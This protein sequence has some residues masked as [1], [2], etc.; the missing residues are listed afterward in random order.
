MRQTTSLTTFLLRLF[1][2]ARAARVLHP[3][4]SALVGVA[5]LVLTSGAAWAQTQLLNVSYDPTRELHRDLSQEFARM[6]KEKTGETVVIRSSHGGSGKQARAVI[7]GLRRR[8]GHP[9]ARGRHRRDRARDQEDPGGLAEAAA[10]QLLALHLDDRLRG[11]EGQSEGHQGLGRPREA[12]ASQVITPNPKTSGGA[13]WNYLA[14]WGYA[15]DK[16][17]GDEAKARDFVA[18][19]LQERAGARYG[20]ARLDHDL[21]P[22]RHRRRA[23]RLGERGLPGAQGVRRRQV[24]DRRARPSRSWPNR[25]S[26]WSTATS[27]RRAR[28]RRRRPISNSSIPA[29]AQAIIAKNYYRPIKPEAADPADLARFPKLEL[30]TIDEVFGGWDKAQSDAFRRRRHVRPDLSS[31]NR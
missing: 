8:R 13:R 19:H 21:R 12:R 27:T 14:A 26:R 2:R 24:R 17:E 3:S 4:R 9:G 16:S 23:D 31:A 29:Q 15:L 30:V 18:A 25:R 7:D 1:A 11:A 28:A 5:A 22:A 20:R 10:A 6:W